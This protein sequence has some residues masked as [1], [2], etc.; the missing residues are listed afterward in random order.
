ME[1]QAIGIHW[2]KRENFNELVKLFDD[3][4][5]LH[6]T[7]PEWLAS[8][9]SLR[10]EIESKGIRVVCVDIDPESFSSWCKSE[11]RRLDADARSE[12]ASMVAY[13]TI[14]DGQ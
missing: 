10:R 5:K 12:Y 8:A 1:L 13:R 2:Y 4:H 9:N 14:T 11:G 7:Y 6:D 3:G